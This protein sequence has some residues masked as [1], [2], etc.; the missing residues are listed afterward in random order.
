MRRGRKKAQ[1]DDQLLESP[2]LM[3]PAPIQVRTGGKH[4][5]DVDAYATPAGAVPG[6]ISGMESHSGPI[7][8]KPTK[9]DAI[10][11]ELAKAEQRALGRR[12]RAYLKAATKSGL[13]R[14]AAIAEVMGLSIE[15]AEA[16]FDELHGEIMR[17]RGHTE[18][19]T[20]LEENDLGIQERVTIMRDWAYS[21]NAAASLNSIKLL[22]EMSGE[23]RAVEPFEKF[24]R[25][26]NEQQRL[27]GGR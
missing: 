27:T 2:V 1:G 26:H 25:L 5:H 23:D 18:I 6:K 13:D 4:E 17:G 11:R 20:I 7:T 24:L 8:R 21:D 10:G 15:E 22:N 14:A 12:Y 16:N 3:L 9:K 19:G